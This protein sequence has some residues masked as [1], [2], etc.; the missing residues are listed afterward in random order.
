MSVRFARS[1]ARP[2]RLLLVGNIPVDVV[3]RVPALPEAGADLVA[4]S[5]TTSA[6]GGFNVLYAAARAGLPGCYGG[7]HGSGP[8]GDLVRVALRTISATLLQPP[9]AGRDS[10]LVLALVDA[11]GER[12]FVTSPDAVTPCTE[13]MLARIRPQ[14][15]DLVYVSGYS[16]G[17]GAA[18]GALAGWVAAGAPERLVFCDLGPRGAAA[19]PG[20][21]AAVL[22]RVDGLSCNAGEAEQL[23]GHGDPR[24]A[25][26]ALSRRAPQAGVLVRAGAAGCWLGLPGGEPEL[27]AAPLVKVVDTNGAGDTHSGYFL[28]AL[29]EGMTPQEAVRLANHAAAISVTRHGPAT[30]PARIELDASGF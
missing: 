27:L 7:A 5:L 9:M 4:E 8:Y 13:E 25:C 11:A 29:A 28:A 26:A 23:T 14:R 3:L 12:T 15:S 24:A 30:A 22:A 1:A 20:L 18:S 2:P 19:A 17:L 10:G 21:L 6:G 16:L